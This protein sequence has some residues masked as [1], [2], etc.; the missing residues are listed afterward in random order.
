MEYILLEL[1]QKE[2]N[3]DYLQMESNNQLSNKEKIVNIIL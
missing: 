1:N 3:K 2:N